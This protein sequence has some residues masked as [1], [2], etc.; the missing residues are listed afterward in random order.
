MKTLEK[1]L[2]VLSIFLNGKEEMTLSEIAAIAGVNKATTNRIVLTL[3]KNGYLHQREKRGKYSLG[4]IYMKFN[5]VLTR[6]IHIREAAFPY[7]EELN[8]K[9]SESIILTSWNKNWGTLMGVYQRIAVS[10]SAL[11]VFPNE[12]SAM[13]LHSTC[14]GKIVLADMSDIELQKYFSGEVAKY[15]ANTIVDIELMRKQILSIREEGIA[16]DDEELDL[17]VRGIAARIDDFEGNLVGT[18]SVVAPAIRFS[19]H[20]IK[21]LA[22]EVVRCASQI[23]NAI[24]YRP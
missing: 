13:P 14:S 12:G 16:L 23:S 6:N 9:V 10:T 8:K 5:K 15:T 3:V 19:L 22:P 11:K 4:T 20:K 7:I 24:G 1:S 17:G 18:I 2:K 21:E